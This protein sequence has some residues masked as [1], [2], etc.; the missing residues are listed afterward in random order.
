VEKR[1]DRYYLILESAKPRE[2]AAV[3][4]DGGKCAGPN[5]RY[6]AQR[7]TKLSPTKKMEDD[8]LRTFLNASV[9]IEARIAAFVNVRL[10]GPDGQE[11]VQN[12]GP[13]EDQITLELA[14][15]NQRL[16]Q[17]QV[18][19]GSL[20]HTWANLYKVLDVMR[21]AH[22]GLSNLKAKHYVPAR[23]IEHF[24]A[25]ANS[26]AAI[27]L[28][29]RHALEEG[30]SEPLMTLNEAQEMFRKLFQGWIQE[31]RN[32]HNPTLPTARML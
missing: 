18:I 10:I 32:Q 20:E 16:R 4:S 13:T 24:K 5:G 11:I 12:K 28:E 2:D 23:D 7:R 3:L 31:L 1:E 25:T 27:G 15:T 22:G 21:E 17:A 14:R 30:V 6:Y 26:Y 9:H 8:S 29:S 19:Y